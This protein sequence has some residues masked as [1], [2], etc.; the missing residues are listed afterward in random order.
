[1]AVGHLNELLEKYGPQGLVI[2]AITDEDRETVEAFAQANPIKYAL[3][4]DA[5]R[6]TSDAYGIEGI[7]S[8]FLIDATGKVAW[9][10]HPLMLEEEQIKSLL[11]AA[12]RET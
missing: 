9:E 3:G 11:A 12:K 2:L 5:T 8:S 1:M 10:G 7:P 6:R 4:M